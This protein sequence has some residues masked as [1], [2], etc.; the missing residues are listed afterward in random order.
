MTRA[1]ESR[2]KA[3][4]FFGLGMVLLLALA[5]TSQLGTPEVPVQA[6][7]QTA[8]QAGVAEASLRSAVRAGFPTSMQPGIWVSGRGEATAVPDLAILNLGIESFGSTVAEAR[9]DAAEAME[10]VMQVVVEFNIADRDFQTRFFNINP[11][12]NTRN[13]TRCVEPAKPEPDS[14]TSLQRMVPGVPEGPALEISRPRSGSECFEE[15]ERV[16]AGYQVTNQLTV[17]LR[18]L[19]GIGE[20]ID[21]VTAAGGDLI[22]F[23]GINF[24]IEDT[25]ELQDQARAA[26]IEDLKAKADQV[27]GLSGVQLGAL[28]NITET[29]GSQRPVFES[30]ERRAL[31]AAAKAPATSISTGELEVVV[32]MQALFGIE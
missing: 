14:A 28:I 9:S 8:P 25:K 11:R 19:D 17:K 10:Q 13:I 32:N 23:Q 2:K 5:C 21:Q 7:D 22:R 29:F 26:A 18:D 6:V 4:L 1:L 3:I 30:L 31:A 20:L 15:R 24:T 16:L 27:A 12:Y